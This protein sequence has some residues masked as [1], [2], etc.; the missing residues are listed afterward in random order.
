MNGTICDQLTERAI[1]GEFVVDVTKSQ[2]WASD[3]WDFQGGNADQEPPL[4]CSPRLLL[5]RTRGSVQ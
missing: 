2:F 3:T 4:V 1:A 5:G